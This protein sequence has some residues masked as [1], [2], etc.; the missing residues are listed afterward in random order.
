MTKYLENPF[1]PMMFLSYNQ[2]VQGLANMDCADPRI[3]RTIN[4]D[5]A[6]SKFLKNVP[7]LLCIGD[8]GTR[9]STLLNDML[10][11]GFEVIEDGSACLFHDSIDMLFDSKDMPMG[12]NVLDF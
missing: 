5:V 3:E 4:L 6:Y 2:K 8:P 10:G 7:N 11:S 1:N 9:K 12:F